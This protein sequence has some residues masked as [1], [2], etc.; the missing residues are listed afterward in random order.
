V[1]S[2]ALMAGLALTSHTSKA[3][4]Q[5]NCGSGGGS[6]G[7]VRDGEPIVCD[8]SSGTKTL[9]SSSG[10]DININMDMGGGSKE[11]AVTVKGQ[12]TNITIIKS[13]KVTGSGGSGLPV[14]K[15]LSGGKLTLDEDVSVD[16]AGAT[17]KKEIVVEGQGSSVTL[18]G[19]LKGFERME[20]KGG[21]AIVLGEKVTGIEE[22]K[23]GINNGGVVRFDKSVTFNNDEAGIKIEGSGGASV[24]G[25]GR[26]MTVTKGSGDGIEMQ[27]TG[28]TASVVGLKIV[29]SGMGST[30]TGVDMQNGREMTLNMVN[31]SGFRVGVNARSGKVNING[32][33]TIT[34]ANSGTGIMV[35]GSGATVKM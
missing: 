35:S 23:V 21:G 15:V 28:G 6:V 14:I 18:K 24:I 32:D 1:V 22:V 8:K 30:G 29:G 17:I 9:N 5:K 4:A 10:G 26:T 7:V 13:L 11:A 2:T 12:G 25:V 31:V 33:S 34:V 3:Y 20:V 27:G 16:V 19:V